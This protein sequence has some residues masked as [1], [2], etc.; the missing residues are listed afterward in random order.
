M[1]KKLKIVLISSAAVLVV[2]FAAFL[3]GMYLRQDTSN[4]AKSADNKDYAYLIKYTSPDISV[5]DCHSNKVICTLDVD[6]DMLP[7]ADK[8]ALR[9]G[10]YIKDRQTLR[11]TIEDIT[12]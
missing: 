3:T 4:F 2:F 7:K 1:S 11:Q 10:I 8:D 6:I 12:G 5:Y 9:Q